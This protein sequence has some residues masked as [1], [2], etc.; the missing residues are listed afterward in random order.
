[1]HTYDR[2]LQWWV[3]VAMCDRGS[4]GTLLLSAC[5]LLSTGVSSMQRAACD[6][7]GIIVNVLTSDQHN[8]CGP[9]PT[10]VQSSES[11]SVSEDTAD[12]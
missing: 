12:S 1:M 11:T 6:A 10:L 3:K 4:T 9:P 8:W 5:Q 7:Y 2:D